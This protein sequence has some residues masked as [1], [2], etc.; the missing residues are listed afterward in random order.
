MLQKNSHYIFLVVR[1]VRGNNLLKLLSKILRSNNSYHFLTTFIIIII[2]SL[3]ILTTF[4]PLLKLS[5][6]TLTTPLTTFT[7]FLVSYNPKL[8]SYHSYH[9]Y[10][11]NNHTPRILV[12]I[13]FFRK[14]EVFRCW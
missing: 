2:I 14:V 1:A 5:L 6:T 3:K 10:R 13:N 4:L 7:R 8:S 11:K 9:S 12:K